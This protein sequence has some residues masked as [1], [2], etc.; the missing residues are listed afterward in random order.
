VLR[1]RSDFCK[2]HCLPL[3]IRDAVRNFVKLLREAKI[4]ET[5]AEADAEAVG[6]V[7]GANIE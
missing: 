2:A 5:E 6:K 3:S 1:C 4:W 7:A